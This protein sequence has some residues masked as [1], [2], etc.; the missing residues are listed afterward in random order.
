M[1]SSRAHINVFDILDTFPH[2]KI[3]NINVTTLRSFLL[4]ARSLPPVSLVGPTMSNGSGTKVRIPAIIPATKCILRSS[5]EGEDED[6]LTL[7]HSSSRASINS[8][9]MVDQITRPHYISD[10]YPPFPRAYTFRQT[11]V[12]RLIFMLFIPLLDKRH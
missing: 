2:I 10:I 6:E 5:G 11:A 3:A 9:R 4:K 12:R 7:S 1:H 8:V